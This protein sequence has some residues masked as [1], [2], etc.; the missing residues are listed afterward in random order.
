MRGKPERAIEREADQMSTFLGVSCSARFRWPQPQT[1]VPS[2]H[3]INVYPMHVTAIIAAGGRGQWFGGAQPKQLLSVGGRPILERTV[4]ALLTHPAIDA[5]IVAV[6]PSLFENPPPYLRSA[7]AFA[8]RG[9]PLRIV[10]GGDR[11]QDS[12][13]NAFRVTDAQ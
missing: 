10:T 11:R 13:A 1:P 2:P 8:L 6:P 5:L 4:M 9:K 12:V 3:I 7:E